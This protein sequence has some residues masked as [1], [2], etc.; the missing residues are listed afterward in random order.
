MLGYLRGVLFN[1]VGNLWTRNLHVE[2]DATFSGTVDMEDA[3]FE[4]V[5]PEEIIYGLTEVKHEFDLVESG[6]TIYVEIE[7][8]GGGDIIFNINGT[9]ATLDCTTGL[10]T[11]G[12][13]RVALTAGASAIAPVTNY[14]Y[15][16]ETA[17]IAT[18]ASSTAVPSGAFA[19]VGKCHVQ[20]AITFAA[21]GPMLSQ[22]FTEAYAHEGRGALSYMREK[23]RWLGAKY[24]S[25]ITYTVNIT[26]NVGVPDDVHLQTTEGQIF[27]LHRH[28]FP[29]FSTG[30]Y[31]W[32]NG[33][34]STLYSEAAGIEEFLATQDGTSMTGKSFNLVFWGVVNK[35]DANCKIFCNVPNDVY[36][37]VSN[38][39]S[40]SN[41]TADTTVPF[42]METTAF[43]IAR[44]CF[45]HSNASG[46]T[47]T[48]EDIFDLRGDATGSRSGG[49]GSAPIST[50]FDDSL[51]KLFNT[52]D[53]TKTA[54]F[55]VNSATSTNRIFILPDV[56][57]TVIV[58]DGNVTF[59]DI[60]NATTI[61]A[62]FIGNLI[63]NSAGIHTGNVIGDLT[64]NS[65]GIHTGNVTGATDVATIT[66]NASG[67][68]SFGSLV[69]TTTLIAGAGF[70]VSS[71]AANFGVDESV[72]VIA[73]F[74]GNAT[75][76][77]GE[78]RWHQG[79][80]ENGTYQHFRA[81]ANGSYWAFGNDVTAI[82]HYFYGDGQFVATSSIQ[83][84][85]A[86]QINPAAGSGVLDF[87]KDSVRQWRVQDDDG[88][89]F[90]L[91]RYN[92]SGVLLDTPIRVDFSSGDVHMENSVVIGATS[93]VSTLTVDRTSGAGQVPQTLGGTT[94]ARFR[95]ATNSGNA[96]VIEI[97][98]GS[99]AYAGI[100][101]GD[102][103]S[104]VGQFLFHNGTR[105]FSIFIAGGEQVN[106]SGT[107]FKVLKD[108]EIDGEIKNLSIHNVG[109]TDADE[110]IASGTY[111]PTITNLLN[112]SSGS[113]V[114]GQWKRVGDIVEV[115][116]YINATHTAT[117]TL[118]AFNISLPVTSNFTLASDLIGNCSYTAGGA[119]SGGTV[120]TNTALDTA[121]C[122]YTS[123]SAATHE[124]RFHFTYEV[125]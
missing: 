120:T 124:V 70:T 102:T 32:G 64:G 10:G 97:I 77:G 71:G 27:Q 72:Q 80:T 108:L 39:L 51:F 3:T 38:A 60:I 118:T 82:T 33:D 34:T 42:E 117:A 100:L 41:N 35:G 79:G 9:Y 46:G 99:N 121:L 56:N 21:Q 73:N 43:L 30:P 116:V 66:V 49:T 109:G 28:T 22:R 4:G 122:Y 114:K 74:F 93:G 48:L 87:F 78:T 50:E 17:S 6:G 69:T 68:G 58:D 105:E 47:W 113:G 11:D 14:I 96:G 86:L 103:D 59:S 92:A 54:Q 18:L 98:A 15:V 52:S 110:S 75:T 63:G 8:V 65:A 45:S 85:G 40:D 13:A 2:G 101:F 67:L 91:H 57:G 107:A 115:S 24:L 53:V 119:V 25:G 81:F 26:P 19:W 12:K 23:L 123:G 112:Y 7:A 44:A 95:K 84:A 90:Q 89:E 36:N 76:S 55:T 29:A 94:I 5:A 31:Y 61:N 20:D 62:A 125:K 88:S 16:T 1:K 37:N 111:T 104:D 106:V 83:T